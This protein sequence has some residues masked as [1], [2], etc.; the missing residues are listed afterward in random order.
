MLR[1]PYV[2]YLDTAQ[3]YEN[4][5]READAWRLLH[6][7]SKRR[8]SGPLCQVRRLLC[9]CKRLALSFVQFPNHSQNIIADQEVLSNS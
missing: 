9:I 4:M 1:D 3:R 8:P 2:A 7:K 5:R 6:S